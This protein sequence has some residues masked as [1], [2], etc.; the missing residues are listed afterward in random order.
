MGLTSCISK[1]WHCWSPCSNNKYILVN[2]YGQRVYT[3][4]RERVRTH[5]P[6]SYIL[7][8]NINRTQIRLGVIEKLAGGR[9][10]LEGEITPDWWISACWNIIVNNDDKVFIDN[11]IF[12]GPCWINLIINDLGP[13]DG[14]NLQQ[15]I[16]LDIKCGYGGGT[17]VGLGDVLFTTGFINI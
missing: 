6:A 11:E 9:T 17:T 10:I 12:K 3:L 13:E 14:Y 15:S 7:L 4:I 1:F 2:F 16:S 8:N 5:H